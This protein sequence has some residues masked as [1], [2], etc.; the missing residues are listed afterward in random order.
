LVQEGLSDN[1][2]FLVNVESVPLEDLEKEGAEKVKVRYLIDERHGSNRFALRIYTVERNGRTP[3]DQHQYEHQVYVL[4]GEGLLRTHENR[5]VLRPVRAGDT[6]FI[7]SNAIHQ[8]INEREEPL[9][10]LCVRGNP[11]QYSSVSASITQSTVE[12]SGH[13][14]C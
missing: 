8:F 5:P 2:I 7:P 12:D 4:S 11:S 10:F 3:L 1:E 13:N 14:F 6:I 9:V